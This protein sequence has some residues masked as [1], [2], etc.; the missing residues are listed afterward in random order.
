MIWRPWSKWPP[1]TTTWRP[2]SRRR[3]ERLEKLL[4]ELEL[5]GL[6]SGPLDAKG[7][8]LTINARDGGTD[9]NDW[10]EMLLRMYLPGPRNTTTSR[11]AGSPGQRRGRHQ[12]RHPRHPRA[13]G[14][15]LSEG[16]NRH[17]SPGADQPLQRRRQAADQFRRGRRFAR[18]QRLG[19]HRAARRGHSRGRLSRQRRRRPARQQDLQRHPP[20]PPAHGHRRAMPERAEPA[21]E[22]GHRA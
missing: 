4:A 7:A 1:K 14:L 12:Q 17:A 9:A 8:I 13:D 2:S 20:D 10:A 19:R 16:R 5:Q 11:V 6:L 18:D 21:Q 3:L 15:W 22:S